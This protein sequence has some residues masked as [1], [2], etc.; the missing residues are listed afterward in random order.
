MQRRVAESSA[1]LK[2][3]AEGNGKSMP[4]ASLSLPCAP[5]ASSTTL[6]DTFRVK[7]LRGRMVILMFG[8]FVASMTY[9]GVSLALDDLPGSLYLNFFLTSVVEFPCYLAS[10][11]VRVLPALLHQL[12]AKSLHVFLLLVCSL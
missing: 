10:I 3:I 4:R 11:A 8:W 1:V 5:S 9:Y 7:E 12:P 6:L 2:S